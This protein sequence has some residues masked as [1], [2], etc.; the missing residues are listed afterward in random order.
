MSTPP[1]GLTPLDCSVCGAFITYVE[2]SRRG[3]VRMMPEMMKLKKMR[4]SGFLTC[5]ETCTIARC[6]K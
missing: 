4:K 3:R 2:Q 6:Q 5:S 1:E